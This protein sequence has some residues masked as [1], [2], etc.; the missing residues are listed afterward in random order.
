VPVRAWSGVCVGVLGFR[1]VE[2]VLLFPFLLPPPL[3]LRG[4]WGRWRGKGAGGVFGACAGVR[5]GIRERVG[6]WF[7]VGVDG[8]GFGF[9]FAFAFALGFGVGVGVEGLG[10]CWG[11]ELGLGL[12]ER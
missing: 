7:G 6:V 12:G 8:L 1:G 5:T 3:P 4:V 11:L 9:A 10:N 2:V